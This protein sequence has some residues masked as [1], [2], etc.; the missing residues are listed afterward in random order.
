MSQSL[1]RTYIRM[2]MTEARQARVPNQLISPD[3]VNDDEG[4]DL[5]QVEQVQ[6]YN[7]TANIMGYSAPLGMNP[8]KLGRLKNRGKKKKHKKQ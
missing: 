4:D 7:T 1:L 2:A 6:E 5:E 3:E 8:N